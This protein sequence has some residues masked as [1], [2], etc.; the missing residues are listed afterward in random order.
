MANLAKYS[1]SGAL[2]PASK[3]EAQK[4]LTVLFNAFPDPQGDTKTK[5]AAFISVCQGEPAWAIVAT[6]KKYLHGLVENHSGKYLPNAAEFGIELRKHTAWH[7]EQA[8]HQKQ[9]EETLKRSETV[10]LTPDQIERRKKQVERADGV[11]KIE[12]RGKKSRHMP[13][14]CDELPPLEKGMGLAEPSP[15]L[16]AKIR[17]KS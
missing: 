12:R 8:K 7:H 9:I 15:E 10:E 6:V 5:T 16:L 4:A 3:E 2:E 11:F 1:A 13:K 17:S 14:W